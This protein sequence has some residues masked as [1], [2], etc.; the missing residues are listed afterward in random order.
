MSYQE[1]DVDGEGRGA[2][3]SRG[4]PAWLIVTLVIAV[5]SALFISQNRGRVK[6]DFVL[7]DRQARLWVVILI[8]MALGAL[9]VEAVRLGAKRRRTSKG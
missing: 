6:V 3:G 1:R 5:L 9:L 7:F 4:V 8:A 2:Q